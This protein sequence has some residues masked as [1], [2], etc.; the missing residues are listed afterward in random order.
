VLYGAILV[1]L[2]AFRFVASRTGRATN[3]TTLSL[4]SIKRETKNAVT[5]RFPVPGNVKLNAKAGQFLTFDWL[6]DGKKHPRSYSL[7][8][9]PLH[10]A[11]IEIT[12]RSKASFLLF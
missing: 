12:V 6:F 2:L 9:S 3:K 4:L 1:V 10:T 8:S 11:Y 5:L 7:S